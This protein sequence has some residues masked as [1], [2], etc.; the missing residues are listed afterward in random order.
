[1]KSKK[2]NTKI[3]LALLNFLYRILGSDRAPCGHLKEGPGEQRCSNEKNAASRS[4]YWRSLG[5]S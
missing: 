1:M 5:P 3:F 2:K 4:A